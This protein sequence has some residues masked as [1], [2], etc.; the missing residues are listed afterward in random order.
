MIGD[1]F[2]PTLE[3]PVKTVPWDKTGNYFKRIGRWLCYTRKWK[4]SEDW[5]FQLFDGTWVKAYKDFILDGA[6]VPKPFRPLLSPT[7][8]LFIPGVFHDCGYR[9]D[10]LFGVI[11]KELDDGYLEVVSEFDYHSGAGKAWWDHVFKKIGYQ[12]SK[13]YIIPNITYLA[14]VVGGWPAWKKHRR[15]KK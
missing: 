11:V 9:H 10:K 8:I 1:K 14:L 13:F 5:Y 7:G 6:S 4:F 3:V 2:K 15:I 12:V